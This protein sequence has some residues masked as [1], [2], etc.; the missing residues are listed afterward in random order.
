MTVQK[1][2]ELRGKVAK[3]QRCKTA[4]AYHGAA[5]ARETDGEGD[6]E[7]DGTEKVTVRRKRRCKENDG[8]RRCD[9]ERDG[10]EKTMGMTVHDGMKARRKGWC[11]AVGDSKSA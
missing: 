9:G 4:K 2:E 10:A 8:A 5:K 7:S 3:S 1:G 6:G 11:T